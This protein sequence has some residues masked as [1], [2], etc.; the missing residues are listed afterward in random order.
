VTR[1]D[2]GGRSH[3]R[4][5]GERLLVKALH[6]NGL[7][8][9]VAVLLDRTGA[10][11]S[12][13]EASGAVA[14]AQP[15]NALGAAETIER[16]V[17]EQGLDELGAGRADLRGVL[18]APRR[19]LHEKVD[20]LGWEMSGEGSPLAGAAAA[21]GGDEGVLVE[22]LDL[23]DGGPHPEPLPDQAMGAGVVRSVEDD[24]A[25]GMQL[26]PL[27]LGDL[28]GRQG[29]REQ[30]GALDLVEALQRDLLGRAVRAPTRN[31]DTPAQQM[32]IALVDVAEG[33]AGECVAL[34]IVLASL[35]DLPFV[36]R[37]ARAAGGR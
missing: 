37:C 2:G 1:T 10:G 4:Q 17:A 5:I 14:L 30:R 32:P 28:P 29:Q 22:E 3:R 7:D 23:D 9:V 12:G 13:V 26:G 11:A 24:V 15:E 6:E 36:L 27:P 8:R 16:P 31:L 19:G 34:G 21:V 18:A 25:V 20:L 35:F 33:P